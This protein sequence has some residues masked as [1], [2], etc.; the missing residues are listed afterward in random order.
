MWIKWNPNPKREE[1]PDCVIR[2][3][4]AA[5]GM[6]W[7]EVFRGLCGLADYECTMPSANWLWGKYLRRLG[8]RP[9]LLPE[10]CPECV[11]VRAFCERFPEGVYIIGAGSHAV[12]V[13]DGN[14][15]DAW[16]SGDEIPAYFWKG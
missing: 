14:Y 3:I 15:Y 10:S 16:D 7:H 5:T 1:E 2:A 6:S 13:L 12:A 4:C 9:F 11:T 8:F